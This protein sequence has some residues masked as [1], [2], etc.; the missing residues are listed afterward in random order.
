MKA[1]QREKYDDV[2]AITGKCMKIKKRSIANIRGSENDRK[3]WNCD[4]NIS[5]AKGRSPE[6]D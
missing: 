1:M 6:S 2:K 4:R 5:R 3:Q